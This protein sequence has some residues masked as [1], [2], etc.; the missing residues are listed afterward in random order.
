MRNPHT[1]SVNV[2]VYHAGCKLGEA[3]L[4][5]INLKTNTIR[6][7]RLMLIHAAGTGDACVTGC[8]N[9][10]VRSSHYASPKGVSDLE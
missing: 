4:G 8:V 10:H 6:Q 5:L 1:D 2:A 9:V 7:V 3:Q